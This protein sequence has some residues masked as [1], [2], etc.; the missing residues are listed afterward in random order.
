MVSGAGATPK[1]IYNTDAIE[2]YA[3]L[4]N[5]L[6]KKIRGIYCSF[7]PPSPLPPHRSPKDIA[8][9]YIV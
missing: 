8:L 1:K 4:K 9:H 2:L 3:F 6:L 5:F 7:T